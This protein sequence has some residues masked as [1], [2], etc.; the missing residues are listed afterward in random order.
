MKMSE[1]KKLK[2][3]HVLKS[4][5]YSGAENVAITIIRNLSDQFEFVYVATE[6]PVRE[7]LE[8]ENIPFIL[9]EKFNRRSLSTVIHK[10]KPDIVH[11]HD[12]S[13][14]VLCASIYGNFRLIS[15]LHYDPPWVRSWNIKTLIYT[16]CSSRIKR[17]IV[18]SEKSFAHMIFATICKKKMTVVGN[19]VDVE[20]IRQLSDELLPHTEQ[21]GC[22]LIFVGRLVTQKNPERFIYLVDELKRNGF[23]N[24]KG[25]MLGIGELETECKIL[26]KKL[27]LEDNILLKGFKKN[28]YPYIKNSKLLCMVSRWEGFGLVLLEA[29]ILGIPV[30]SSRTAGAEEVLGEKSKELCETDQEFLDKIQYIL[31]QPE[32]YKEYVE[33]A[34]KRTNRL[35]TMPEYMKQIERVYKGKK[36]EQHN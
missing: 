29:N 15:H 18:V 23:A 22:D 7:T 4:S 6:G 3:L 2:V 30:L 31:R 12:F 27:N 24:I 36:D 9:L 17:V 8:Q 28:P 21:E 33:L 16:L 19:P 35:M 5:I 14:T 32:G 10:Y 26:I 11:A 13:A 34:S 20:K 25:W 1:S